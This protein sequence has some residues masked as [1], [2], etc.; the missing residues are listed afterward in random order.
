MAFIAAITYVPQLDPTTFLLTDT[1]NYAS[2]D[3]KSNM[4]ARTITILQADGTALPGYTNPISFPYNTGDTYTITGLTKDLALQI[5]MILTP[6]SPNSGSSYVAIASIATERFLQQGLFNI[7]VQRLNDIQP[8][9]MAD[10]QYRTNSIDLILEGQNAQTAVLYGNFT[11]GQLALN[12]TQNIIL[13][14]TL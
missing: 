9:S 3:S 5:T 1:S 2:P 7:Q 10:Q 14:T 8:N 11:G 6:I 12:R 4:S 13:N